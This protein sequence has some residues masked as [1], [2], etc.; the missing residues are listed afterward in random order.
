MLSNFYKATSPFLWVI[1]KIFSTS[2]T[3]EKYYYTI[4]YKLVQILQVG[5]TLFNGTFYYE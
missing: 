3:L 2:R 1:Q 4:L 5:L